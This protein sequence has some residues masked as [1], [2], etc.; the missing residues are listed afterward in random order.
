VR[1]CARAAGLAA[2]LLRGTHLLLGQWS[3]CLAFLLLVVPL[4][5][6]STADA[7]R[8]PLRMALLGFSAAAGQLYRSG[9]TAW[10]AEL[11]TPHVLLLAITS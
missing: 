5:A 8:L 11:L 4:Y 10:L 2:A 6:A 9:G 7:P 3:R 1:R